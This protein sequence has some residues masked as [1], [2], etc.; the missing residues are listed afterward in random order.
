[1]PTLELPGT[2]RH[3]HA[4]AVLGAALAAGSASHA[5]LF[6]GPAGTGK[7]RVA[8]ALATHLLGGGTRTAGRVERHAHPD[9]SW[10]VPS[11]AHE[12]LVGDVEPVVAAASRT[13]FEAER[14]VF[15]LE[16][17]DTLVEAAANKLLKTLE[18]PP[19][20]AHLILLTDRVG[21]V[22]PTIASRCQAVRFDPL[23]PEELAEG[24][25][26]HGIGPEPAR[27]AARL[28][29][30]DGEKA[31]ALAL[32]DGPALR[33]GAERLARAALADPPP[34]APWD[35]LL[36]AA[37]ARGDRARAETTARGEAE[38]EL[39][40]AKER[41]RLET[42]WNERAKR[43]ERR[44]RTTGLDLGLQLTGLWYR[45]VAAVV[46]GAEDHAHHADRLPALREE[47][48]GFAAPG[49][50]LAA[51]ELVEDTRRRLAL[52]VSEDLALEALTVRLRERL[53]RADA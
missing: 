38:K 12:M 30:G 46:L 2:E 14:R 33:D 52:N 44:A 42:A 6:H 29:L 27:A 8:R 43:A 51:A 31:L 1:M 45:D 48:A 35:R 41:R 37:A 24:L 32:G 18:E 10:V 4:R 36:K 20:Y 9:L 28:A 22:L 39:V 21:E 47:A 50:L 11:G 34:S 13:P 25:A 5:Y 26:R 16:R 17:S 7:A 19:V 15:V 3:P 40:P 53:A 49:R 23:P